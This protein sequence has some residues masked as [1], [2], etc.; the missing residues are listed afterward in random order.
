MI[1]SENVICGSDLMYRLLDHDKVFTIKTKKPKPLIFFMNTI[2][3][4]KK[5]ANMIWLK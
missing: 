2:R 5:R 1:F 4:D 3:V